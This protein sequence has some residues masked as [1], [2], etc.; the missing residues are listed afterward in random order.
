MTELPKDKKYCRYCGS[1]NDL[2]AVWCER[3][4]KQIRSEEPSQ[5]SINENIQSDQPQAP[6]MHNQ[7]SAPSSHRSR[8]IVVGIV[9][10]II[11]LVIVVG[12]I[13]YTT[14]KTEITGVNLQVKYGD[15]DQG[16]FG[17]VSQTLALSNQ[18]TG[19]LDL[20]PGQQLYYSFKFTESALATSD[21]SITGIS[22]STPGFTIVSVDPSTPIAFSPGSSKTITVTLQ[23][24]QTSFNG[25]INLVLSTSGGV[26]PLNQVQIQVQYSGAWSGAYGDTGN[27]QSWS[28]TGAYTLTLDRPLGTTMWIISANA[29]KQ[30]SSS[31]PLTISIL[32]MDGTVLKTSSTSTAYGLA[33][34]AVSVP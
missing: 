32:K 11:I 31:D 34:V 2:D 1:T 28:G 15:Y 19:V 5:Q 30:D 21:D 10:G 22:V 9:L 13:S 3:C 29:Q 4:G 25:A 7:S 33:Q 20:A 8:K 6:I 26:A 17:P 27:I 14:A 18:P 12:I 16:Y 23:S 24:P